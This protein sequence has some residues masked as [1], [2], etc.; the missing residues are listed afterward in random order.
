MSGRATQD[1]WV[2]VKS[3][4]KTWSIG[5]GNG[6]PLK[7]SCH[8]SPMNIMKK[9]KHRTLED[10]SSR[11]ED[12]QYATGEEWRAITNSSRKYEAVGPKQKRCS[13]VDVSGVK[14]KSDTVKNNIV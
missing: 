3:S 7:Y 10:E 13:V 11:W 9:Q 6:N 8:E 2:I 1:R 4:D 5:G 14:V 12:V